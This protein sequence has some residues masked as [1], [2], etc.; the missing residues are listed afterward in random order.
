[1]NDFL[2]ISNLKKYGIYDWGY[3]EEA[4]PKSFDFF[5]KRIDNKFHQPFE[6]LDGERRELRKSLH[7]FFP[8]FKSALVFLFS[9]LDSKLFLGD[10]RRIAAFSLGFGGQDYHIA[11]R[12]SLNDISEKIK[13]I[14]AEINIIHSLDVHPVLERDLAWRAGLGHIGKNSMLINDKIGSYSIIGSLLLS[15]KLKDINFQ[16]R[17]ESTKSRESICG[18]CQ[19][20]F[21]SCPTGALT[22]DGLMVKKCASA[23]TIEI[24]NK[25]FPPA[26][27]S[28]NCGIFG[29]DICQD[30]CPVN[31][32]IIKNVSS[33]DFPVKRGPEFNLIVDFFLKRSKDEIILDLENMSNRAFER[34]FAGTVFAR[35]GR[36]AILGSIYFLVGD[37]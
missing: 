6:F 14:D 30:V 27:F 33:D 13:K 36:K 37:A 21:Q 26:G 17:N 4:V 22:D 11:V 16:E 2:N 23:F 28:Q 31:Q 12:R 35:T 29:C 32:K 18:D 20:C 7:N 3:T 9:Y 1:M 10:S 24:K 8:E 5:S 25:E 19:I 15:K 34:M